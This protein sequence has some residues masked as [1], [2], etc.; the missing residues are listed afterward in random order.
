MKKQFSE[1]FNSSDTMSTKSN[2]VLLDAQDPNE[3]LT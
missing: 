3:V 1:T 2:L